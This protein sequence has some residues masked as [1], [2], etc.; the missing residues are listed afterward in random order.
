M[1]DSWETVMVTNLTPDQIILFSSRGYFSDTAMKLLEKIGAIK[2]RIAQ[3]DLDLEALGK[4]RA[5]IFEDQKRLRENLRGLGQTAEEKALRSRYVNQLDDQETRLKEIA[6]K[7]V[8]LMEQ[9]E[10]ARNQ[11]EK[12]MT[13]LEQDFQVNR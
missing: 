6:Q 1:R 13:G 7:N 8:A 3:I 10:A 9:K 5:Q 4:E 2:S 12:L 11:L